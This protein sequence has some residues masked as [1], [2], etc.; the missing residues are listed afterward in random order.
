MFAHVL[1]TSCRRQLL[2]GSRDEVSWVRETLKNLEEHSPGK[3]FG[4]RSFRCWCF[5]HNGCKSSLLDHKY[6]MLG[7]VNRS[8]GYSCVS[9]RVLRSKAC[10]ALKRQSHP[11]RAEQVTAKDFVCVCAY[12]YLLEYVCECVIHNHNSRK[13]I[14]PAAHACTHA[15]THLCMY[16]CLLKNTTIGRGR[17]QK[18]VFCL[19]LYSTLSTICRNGLLLFLMHCAMLDL[20]LSARFV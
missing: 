18:P 3:V 15:H 8:T 1:S 2:L 7:L 12:T 11:T 19:C 10:G 5:R 6:S 14:T 13:T 20:N 4:M 17:S 16:M 9:V